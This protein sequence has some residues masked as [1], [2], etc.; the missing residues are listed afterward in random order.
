M[1]LP[2]TGIDLKELLNRVEYELIDQALDRTGGNRN[3]AAAL[4]GLNRT[5]LVEKLKRRQNAF[6]KGSHS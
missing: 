2:E 1:T 6:G 4:L 3:Q 5:T